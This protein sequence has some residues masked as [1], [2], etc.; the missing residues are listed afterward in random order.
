MAG[1]GTLSLLTRL[2]LRRP[3]VTILAIVMVLL[4]GV[5]T[6]RSLSVE[7]FPEIEFPLVTVS[8]F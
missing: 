3:A 4:S 1:D 7:L 6:Y 5:L 2:A 8:T